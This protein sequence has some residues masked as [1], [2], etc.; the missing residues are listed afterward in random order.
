M[1]A[2][3]VTDGRLATCGSAPNCVSSAELRKA[4]RVPAMGYEGSSRSIR[5]LILK[6]LRGWPHTTIVRAGESY[7]L[8]ECKS[9]WF[10]FVDDLEIYIDEKEERIQFRSAS[11][12]GYSDLGANRKRIK[13][14]VDALAKASSIRD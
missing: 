7:I 13:R 14:L 10:G 6:V 9:R 4:Y 5:E 2:K 11:R 1:S 8:A 12:V 3:G